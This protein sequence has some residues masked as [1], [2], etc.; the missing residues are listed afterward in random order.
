ME[1]IV[2]AAIRLNGR[3]PLYPRRSASL[4]RLLA[5]VQRV[6]RQTEKQCA[7]PH[8]GRNLD[9]E[10]SIDAKIYYSGPQHF[11]WGDPIGKD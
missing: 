2:R 6:K 4:L 10:Q 11:L 7:G 8:I 5:C 3:S 1:R 9:L